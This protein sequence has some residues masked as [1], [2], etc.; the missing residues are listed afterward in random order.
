MGKTAGVPGVKHLVGTPTA[1]LFEERARQS[2]SHSRIGG[3][4]PLGGA[5]KAVPKTAVKTIL[6]GTIIRFRLWL[7]LV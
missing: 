6:V 5:E 1:K 7:H 4:A 2:A 3:V